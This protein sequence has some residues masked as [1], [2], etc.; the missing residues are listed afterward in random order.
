LAVGRRRE[1]G[2]R[3]QKKAAKAGI[4]KTKEKI[5]NASYYLPYS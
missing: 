4:R 5:I 3:R 2:G 1:A